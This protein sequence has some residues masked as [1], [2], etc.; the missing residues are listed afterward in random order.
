MRPYF[1]INVPEQELWET[2]RLVA[3]YLRNS[4]GIFKFLVQVGSDTS[5]RKTSEARQKNKL[6]NPKERQACVEISVLASYF[7]SKN[8][9]QSS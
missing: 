2:R 5:P 7:H 9:A 1:N 4:M 3:D 8:P 6:D